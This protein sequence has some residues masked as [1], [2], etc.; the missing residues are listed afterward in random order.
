[1]KEAPVD[2][3]LLFDAV[4]YYQGAFYIFKNNKL[5]VDKIK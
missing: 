2:E 3:K 1:M 5:K 4:A